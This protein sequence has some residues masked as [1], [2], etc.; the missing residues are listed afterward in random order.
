MYHFVNRCV[1]VY[2][3]PPHTTSS[4]VKPVISDTFDDI[5]AGPSHYY[6]TTS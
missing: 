1:P 2:S 6:S 4:A 5:R 3:L